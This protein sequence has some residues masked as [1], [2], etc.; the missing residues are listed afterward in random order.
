MKKR[1]LALLLVV[2]LAASLA[3]CAFA[4]EGEVVGNYYSFTDRNGNHVTVPVNAFA[5][6]VI[7]F[8]P[9][10]PWK[11]AGS[12]NTDPQIALGLPD[13]DDSNSST[14]DLCLGGSGVLVLGF[15][16]AIFD[17]SG[18]DLYVFEVGNNVEDTQVEV[19]EDLVTWYDVGVATGRTAGVDFSGKVPDGARIRY[20]RLTDL[21][22]AASGGW[23]G[24]DIDTVCG[25]RTMAVSSPFV[26]VRFGD[27]FY[28]SVLWAINHAPQITNGTDA[29]HFSPANTVTRAQAVT[30]LWRSMGEP[31]PNTTNSPFT[32]VQDRSS[33]YYDAVLWAV[34]E[35]I[36]N[37]TSATTFSPDST[38]TKGQMVTFLYRTVGEPGKTG[39]GAWYADAEAWAKQNGL[40]TGTDTA[41]STDGSCPRGDVV[42]YLWNALA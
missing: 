24:A 10:D 20:V 34:G 4:E 9:G 14:G 13:A 35:G 19:S 3:P 25:I 17:G 22:S 21:R 26:D 11:E 15:D 16:V 38:V 8:T 1:I 7:S 33:W 28:D 12:S 5:S 36:T 30:F 37:G 23:P 2:L 6:E 39:T 31:Q 18:D 40:L 41:Y 42:Y 32:D 29:T 27:Y